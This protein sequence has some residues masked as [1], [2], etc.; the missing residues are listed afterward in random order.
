MVSG[1]NLNKKNFTIDEWPV[2]SSGA[3][4]VAAL[5]RPLR[6]LAGLADR[7]SHKHFGKGNIGYYTTF[8]FKHITQFPVHSHVAQEAYGITDSKSCR[9]KTIAASK[10]HGIR[11]GRRVCKSGASWKPNPNIQYY[12]EFRSLSVKVLI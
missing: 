2:L 6:N 5:L 12:L 4:R 9:W 1:T 7:I 10:C 3:R 11:A 8:S